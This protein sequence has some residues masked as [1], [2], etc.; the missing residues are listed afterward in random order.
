VIRYGR[1]REP[2]VSLAVAFKASEGLVLAADSR[3]TL[4]VTAKLPGNPN[5]WLVPA[6]Y[7]NATKLLTVAGQ[8]YVAAS[9]YGVGVI[10]LQEP[11]T[12]H[13]LLPEFEAA[14]DPKVRLSVEDFAKKLS[15][16]FA[17]Q[18]KA[19][20]PVGVH[21]DDMRFTADGFDENQPYGRIFEFGIPSAPAPIEQVV[22]DFGIRFG[23]QNELISRILN[24]YDGNTLEV[25]KAK[26]ALDAAK[27]AAL[28]TEIQ[29]VSAAKIPYQFLPL[30]DCVDLSILLIRTT[31]QLMDY[32]TQLRGV[33]GMVDVV[34]ITRQEGCRYVQRKEIHGETARAELY[35]PGF[36]K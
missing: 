15:E 18:W 36:G 34:V 22:N 32:Q 20:M 28:E 26:F 24:G 19:K 35:R 25:I 8:K 27:S 13:S 7:D 30:Q 21:F 16:F 2:A 14:L 4:T 3:V 6:T 17:D 9:T 33:G 29:Q 5:D 12:A 10:G 11:R 31:S 1:S 23:G